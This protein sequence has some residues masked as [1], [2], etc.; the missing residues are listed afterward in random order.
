MVFLWCWRVVE[1]AFLEHKRALSRTAQHTKHGS[2]FKSTLTQI[3]K[4]GA[5]IGYNYLRRLKKWT[6]RPSF[7]D[8]PIFYHLH[9]QQPHQSGLQDLAALG[10]HAEVSLSSENG[11]CVVRCL[12]S[13]GHKILPTHHNL[14]PD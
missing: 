7:A 2:K 5:R 13:H 11:H 3:R 1:T 9:C 4:V 8:A 12:P 14:S 6:L 10:L